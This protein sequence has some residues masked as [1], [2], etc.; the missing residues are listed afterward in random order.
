MPSPQEILEDIS[1]ED[2]KFWQQHEEGCPKDCEKI[3]QHKDGCPED[4]KKVHRRKAGKPTHKT[5]EKFKLRD[6]TIVEIARHLTEMFSQTI[7]HIYYVC[8]GL[9]LVEKDHGA[10]TYW[11]GQVKDAIGEAR[12]DS[13]I[14]WEKIADDSR[15]LNRPS[16]WDDAG[17]FVES[18]L[19]AFN[20]DRW[21]GQTN[22]VIV[23]TEKD[24][25]FGMLS[26]L[27]RQYQVPL[28]SFHGQASDGGAIYKLAKH[29]AAWTGECKEVTCFYLGDFD[30]C[31]CVIDR[32]AFGDSDADAESDYDSYSG[33]LSRLVSQLTEYAS[34][35]P[36]VWY[37]RIGITPFDVMNPRYAA[38]LLPMNKDTNAERYEAEISKFKDFPRVDGIPATLGIDALDH[39]ELVRRTKESIKSKIDIDAWKKQRDFYKL[40]KRELQGLLK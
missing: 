33:K 4:C 40:H 14:G 20:V 38:Y 2:R 6:A 31:G 10:E 19:P 11:Y 27:C 26:G 13:R 7:R 1:L 22:R 21:K 24:A 36:F 23:C 9:G 28:M 35:A 3:H 29:I 18:V 16:F 37:K 8:S 17:D 39:L 5:I 12:W 32:V 25:I 30:T 15:P 34:D